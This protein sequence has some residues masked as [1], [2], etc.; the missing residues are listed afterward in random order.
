M[1]PSSTE[2]KLKWGSLI[3]KEHICFLKQFNFSLFK[4]NNVSEF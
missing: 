4:N 3:I 2:N 1:T